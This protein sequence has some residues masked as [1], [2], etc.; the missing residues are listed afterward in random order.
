M[1]RS[2]AGWGKGGLL[3]HCPGFL[4]SVQ[5]IDVVLISDCLYQP[6]PL[7]LLAFEFTAIAGSGHE[8]PDPSLKEEVQP[9]NDNERWSYEKICAALCSFSGVCS[10]F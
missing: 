1:R 9:N 4:A 7:T 5:T 10:R 3:S 8:S 2:V 6:T